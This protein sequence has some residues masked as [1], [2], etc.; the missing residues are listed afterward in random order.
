MAAVTCLSVLARAQAV[1]LARSLSLAAYTQSQ[2]A[3][4]APSRSSPAARA[5]GPAAGVLQGVVPG[6]RSLVAP[7]ACRAVATGTVLCHGAALCAQRS[8]LSA[9]I[10]LSCCMSAPP[11]RKRG[12]AGTVSVRGPWSCRAGAVGGADRGTGYGLRRDLTRVCG[13]RAALEWDDRNRQDQK[14]L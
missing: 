14:L 11:M 3:R 5:A 4:Q 9:M 7:R 1:S 10:N 13:A 6:P 2:G 8:A 12:V